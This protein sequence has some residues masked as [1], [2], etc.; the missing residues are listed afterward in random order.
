MF[1]NA[2]GWHYRSGGGDQGPC[3]RMAARHRQHGRVPQ[4]RGIGIAYQRQQRFGQRAGFVEHRR[5][6]LG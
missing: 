6:D 1:R 4:I 2:L 5:I 3:E